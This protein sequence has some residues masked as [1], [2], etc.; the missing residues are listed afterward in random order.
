[1]LLFVVS[2]CWLG[3]VSAVSPFLRVVGLHAAGCAGRRP[4]PGRLR[5]FRS[6]T[7]HDRP[8]LRI[9][10][11]VTKGPLA[12]PAPNGVGIPGAERNEAAL[13]SRAEARPSPARSGGHQ[14]VVP[15]LMVFDKSPSVLIELPIMYRVYGEMIRKMQKD[16]VVASCGE[17]GVVEF[18]AVAV[19]SP[20]TPVA[21]FDPK[22]ILEVADWTNL[23]LAMTRGLDLLE[24]RLAELRTHGVPVKRILLIV[25]SDFQS[26]DSLSVLADRLHP[27]E[28]ANK[29]LA[30]LP[31]G[32]GTVNAEVMNAFSSKRQGLLL[33]SEGGV[34]CYKPLFDWIDGVI[35]L[36]SR[37]RPDEAVDL[38]PTDGWRRL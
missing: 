36:F 11:V 12:R 18:N 15:A 25:L 34:P 23:G 37:S 26:H 8:P 31:I 29:N 33:K 2:L 19:A 27:L 17:I 10:N 20:F 9:F 6:A 38:P 30:V 1:M 5:M 16:P 22:P 14:P 35:G 24:A 7:P 32:F 4:R 28:R 13:P 21:E 3:V